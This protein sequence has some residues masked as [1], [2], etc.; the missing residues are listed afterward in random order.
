MFVPP[1]ILE[2]NGI[3]SRH[4]TYRCLNTPMYTTTY[5]FVNRTRT[6]SLLSIRKVDKKEYNVDDTHKNGTHTVNQ[7]HER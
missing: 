3:R 5:Y 2:R 1:S 4:L 7:Q 6:S